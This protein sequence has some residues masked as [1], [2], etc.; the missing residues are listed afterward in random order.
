MS[1]D[2]IHDIE[3]RFLEDLFEQEAKC[4]A[5]EH[6]TGPCPENATH[7]CLLGL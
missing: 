7:L 3:T 6:E 1:L 5:E 4:E 2:T